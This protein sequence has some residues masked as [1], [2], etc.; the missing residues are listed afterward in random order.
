MEHA[1]ELNHS[2]SAL[3]DSLMP[4]NLCDSGC[5]WRLEPDCEILTWE[6]A[7]GYEDG[8]ALV[9][10]RHSVLTPFTKLRP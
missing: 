6:L 8:Y 1:G 5:G 9:A 10:E 2:G 7:V 3:V 4:E